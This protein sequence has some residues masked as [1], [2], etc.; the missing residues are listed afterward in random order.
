M[1]GTNGLKVILSS[2]TC[3]RA[4]ERAREWGNYHWGQSLCPIPLPYKKVW[5][6]RRHTSRVWC[7]VMRVHPHSFLI[8]IL[9]CTIRLSSLVWMCLSRVFS[10]FFFFY[11]FLWAVCSNKQVLLFTGQGTSFA[12]QHIAIITYCHPITSMPKSTAQSDASLGQ[13]EFTYKKLAHKKRFIW[14]LF[15]FQILEKKDSILLFN[16]APTFIKKVF[17]C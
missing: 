8:N 14:A 4:S 7:R 17:P 3:E 12:M 1:Q 5:S 2:F 16:H 15:K 6:L 11:F 10:L 13:R 9:H